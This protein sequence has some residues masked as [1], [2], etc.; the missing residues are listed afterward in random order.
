[1]SDVSA[2]PSFDAIFGGAPTVSAEAPGRVNLIGEHT[3][4]HEGFVLPTAVPQ[5]TRVEI[6]RRDDT[7]VQAWTANFPGDMVSFEIGRERPA[8]RW[9]DYVQGA[10]AA[11][12]RRGYPVTG[13]D[14]RIASTVPPGGGLS[15]SAALEIS[16][17][18]ALRSLFVLPLDDLSLATLGRQVET[19]FVGAPVGIMD[20]MA[21]SLA[22]PGEALL[23]DTRSLLFERIP[24]PPDAELIVINSGVPHQHALGEY[25]TRQRESFEAAAELGVGVLRD[26]GMA[27]LPRINKLPAVL[28]KRA[29]HVVTENDRVVR[30][31]QALREHDLAEFGRLLDASHV[32]MRDDYEISTPEIDALVAIGQRDPD[33][34]GARLTG[35][36]FGGSVVMVAR[37]GAGLAAAARVLDLYHRQTGLT[38]TR[39]L[40]VV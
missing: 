7:R 19:D 24:L 14:V 26:M 18:R 20:Q 22:R 35:G 32:S 36:G 15:S 40:P 37:A 12:S 6:R 16:L 25:A 39:L 3:D 23:L 5:R 34:R 38:G 4:Y 11:L 10:T 8:H 27:D 28:A 29:R 21:S 33:V 30:A 1:M 2:L 13:F 9:I 17:L 31:A